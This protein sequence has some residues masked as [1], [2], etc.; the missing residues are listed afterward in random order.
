[1]KSNFRKNKNIALFITIVAIIV[2]SF[3]FIYFG[4]KEKRNSID[5]EILY[6][7]NKLEL[8]YLKQINKLEQN[9]SNKIKLFLQNEE[10]LKSFESRDRE[11]LAI[12]VNPYLDKFKKE[13]GNFELICFALPSSKAFYRVHKPSYFGDNIGHLV[14]VSIV[15][16]QRREVG[17]FMISK[18]GLYYRV[19]TPVYY[20][21]NYIGLVSFGINIGYVNDF[22]SEEFGSEVA[23]LVDT[24]KNE[25]KQWFSMLEEGK[26]DNFTIIASTNNFIEENSNKI[27]IRAKTSKI[28][29]DDKLYFVH[30]DN[31][32]YNI[33]HD[34]IAKILL[35]QDITEEEKEYA[36]YLNNSIW[37]TVIIVLVVI[38]ILMLTFNKLINTIISSNIKLQNTVKQVEEQTVELEDLNKSLENRIKEEVQ[39][40]AENERK[41][42]NQSKQAALGDMIGNIAHQWRQPL[43]AISTAASAMRV[44]QDLGILNEDD[45]NS[46]TDGIIRNS[47]YL[48]QTIDDFRDFIKSEKVFKEF[49][50]NESIDK[51]L[52][53]VN[54]S[55]NNHKLRVVKNYD[56]NTKIN[57]YD[58]EL[59]QVIINIFNNAK[60]ALKEK[61]KN[62]EDRIIFIDTY[63][64]EKYAYIKIKDT[65]TGIPESILHK[66]FEP[67][68]TTKHQSQ[69]T[70]LGLYMSHQIVVDSMCGGIDVENIEFIY[71]DKSYSGA[72]FIL[73]FKL[74]RV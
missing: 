74:D 60:D 65:A 24:Q 34:M 53:I 72:Q 1:M 2:L 69:G 19:T 39:K 15:N 66:I 62:E 21:N 37:I 45:I 28:K 41:L 30:K 11:K 16:S 26:I 71:K 17:G 56:G 27:D 46:Y 31:N 20:N 49:Y 58:N 70:G 18:L 12:V 29:I 57:N 55:I 3:I 4:L 40:N 44:N 61:V 48:S 23:L 9:Y 36:K 35:F 47:N 5:K 59:Q 43:S 6:K 54:S 7:K 68:F 51:C 64:D 67:Y 25:N 42:A 73:S 22:I 32:I 52:A 38:T 50:I 33:N 63:K 13:N 10:V 8:V 14:D